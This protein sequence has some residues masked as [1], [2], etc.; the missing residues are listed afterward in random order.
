MPIIQVQ[1]LKGRSKE[2][3]KSLITD[4]TNA[5]AKNLSIHPDRV[6]VLV[7]EIHDTHWGAGGRT[8]A[9]RGKAEFS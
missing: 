7:S 1:I 6:R 9:E 5:C 8:M 3:I 4:I 2:Q